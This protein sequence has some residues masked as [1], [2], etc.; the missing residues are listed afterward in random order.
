MRHRYWRGT[1]RAD[2]MIAYGSLL[3]MAVLPIFIAARRS[4]YTQEQLKVHV[5]RYHMYMPC[6]TVDEGTTLVPRP[7]AKLLFSLVGRKRF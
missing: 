6:Y 1:A 7:S 3:I 5:N 4:V 2:L